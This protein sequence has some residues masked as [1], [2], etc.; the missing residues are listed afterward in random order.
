MAFSI[1]ML[2][3]L[4]VC[5]GIDYLSLKRIDQNGALL[6]VT[7]PPDAAALPE[8]Q[9]IVQQ[10]LRWLRIIC[11]LCAA[12]GVGLFF[13]PDSLLRVMVWVYFFFGSLALPYLPCLWANRTLQRL[14]DAHGWPAAP[15]DVPW[16]YG[17]SIMLLTTRAPLCLSAS[18][19]GLPPTSPPSGGSL[20]WRSMPL[21]SLP[22]Y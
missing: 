20:L 18:A 3:C 22:S 17:L 21:Q 4:I 8:V 12:G 9:S 10:Y 5:V 16:K 11:L 1:I 14:R 13:L 15:G 7:L 19:R 6:G 2:A